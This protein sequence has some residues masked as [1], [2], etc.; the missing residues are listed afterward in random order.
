MPDAFQRNE[1]S[2]LNRLIPGQDSTSSGDSSSQDIPEYQDNEKPGNYD[3]TTEV[4]KI[5]EIVASAQ[6]KKEINISSDS[7]E[8]KGLP[9]ISMDQEDK[10]QVRSKAQN[11][12]KAMSFPPDEKTS[13]DKST[14]DSSTSAKGEDDKLKEILIRRN[15]LL[16]DGFVRLN[17]YLKNIRSQLDLLENHIDKLSQESLKEMS[18]PLPDKGSRPRYSTPGEEEVQKK[19]LVDEI[20]NS[21]KKSTAPPITLDTEEAPPHLQKNE[22]EQ[23]KDGDNTLVH[24]RKNAQKKQEQQEEIQRSPGDSKFKSRENAEVSGGDQVI[25]SFSKVRESLRRIQGL[26]ESSQAGEE[27][28]PE[29]EEPEL[30]RE[31]PWTKGNKETESKVS[32]GEKLT[33]RQ[34][35]R[36]LKHS[37]KVIRIKAAEALAKSQLKSTPEILIDAWCDETETEVRKT[38]IKALKELDYKEAVSFF[39]DALDEDNVNTQMAALEGLYKF[40]TP[41][42]TAGFLK[43]LRSRFYHIRRRAVTYLGWNRVEVAFPQLIKMLKDENEFVRKATISTLFS[44]RNKEAIPYLIEV[45]HD[46]SLS[47]RKKAAEVLYR[48]TGLRNDFVPHA[49]DSQRLEGIEQWKQW[50]QKNGEKFQ[51]SRIYRVEEPVDSPAASSAPGK[52]KISPTVSSVTALEL[53]TKEKEKSKEEEIKTPV[54]PKS[55]PIIHPPVEKKTEKE[56]QKEEGEETSVAQAPKSSPV[57][58]PPVVKKKKVLTKRAEKK[59]TSQTPVTEKPSRKRFTSILEQEPLVL[60]ADI[61]PG[62]MSEPLS[63]KTKIKRKRPASSSKLQKAIAQASDGITMKELG[64]KMDV[65]WQTL[66]PKIDNLI[67]TKKIKKIENKYFANKKPSK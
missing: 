25:Q 24:L 39:T 14:A 54:V 53:K 4:D 61:F 6:S 21:G 48:W 1:S 13:S 66:I 49:S 57:I 29:A 42:A 35:S 40:E 12:A 19:P 43:A 65:K 56:K 47:I 26:M 59:E 15:R 31:T 11:T 52:K 3:D 64:E 16:S 44:F 63:P 50:W 22:A 45:L 30:K 38:I 33:F 46:S 7:R 34:F 41:K 8:E 2:E 20:E 9:L 58:H 67:K 27:N 23:P 60:A 37:D 51:I 28:V 62:P 55:P 17:L 36:D 5:L 32:P 18:S 10:P